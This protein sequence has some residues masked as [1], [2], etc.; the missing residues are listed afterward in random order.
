MHTQW[1]YKF[2]HFSFLWVKWRGKKE[3][4]KCRLS[5]HLI[6]RF[7]WFLGKIKIKKKQGLKPERRFKPLPFPPFPP[8]SP[9][10]LPLPPLILIHRLRWVTEHESGVGFTYRSDGHPEHPHTRHHS[11]IATLPLGGGGTGIILKVNIGLSFYFLAALTEERVFVSLLCPGISQLLCKSPPLP[12]ASPVWTQQ[13][14]WNHGRLNGSG[15]DWNTA[16]RAATVEKTLEDI[17]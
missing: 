17:C 1:I 3:K 8:P 14:D 2:Y 7:I 13:D 5:I 4:R 16:L 9:P 6:S 10:P 12:H 15:H 11:Q